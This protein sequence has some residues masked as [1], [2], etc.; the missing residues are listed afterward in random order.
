VARSLASLSA[1]LR[2]QV[3]ILVNRRGNITH[4]VV[5]DH[6]GLFIPD[7]SGYRSATSRLR[8]LRL[9]HTHLN[10]EPITQD[11]LTDLALLHLD[12][13]AAIAVEDQGL[14]G[15]VFLAHLLP[16]NLEHTQWTLLEFPHPAHIPLDFLQLIA[17]LEEEFER[18]QRPGRLQGVQEKAILV[19]VSI[20]AKHEAIDS[21]EE[22][23]DLAHSCNIA[24]A[25]KIIQHRQHIDPRHLLGAGKLRE[26]AIRSLQLGA[27]LLIFDGELTPTQVK[28]I[29]D[30]TEM[31]VIDRT[32][33]ILDIFSQRAHSKEGKIQ[34]ELAQLKYRLPRLVQK[35][36]ALSRLMGGIG[37]RGPGEQKLEIDRRRVRE[38]II[39]LE[40]EIG[41]L[42]HRRGT[43]RKQRTKGDVPIIS[44]VGYTNAGKSTLLNSL[45]HSSVRVEDRLFATL[46]PASRRLRFPRDTEAIITDTVGFIRDLPK[47]LVTAFRATL[48]ELN[49]ADLLVH[50]IDISNPNYE[51]QMEACEKLLTHLELDQ[52]PLIRV[53]NKADRFED[54]AV[55]D[56]LARLH[57]AINISA[58]DPPT[59]IPL[60]ERIEEMLLRLRPP[61]NTSVNKL[62]VPADLF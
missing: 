41:K 21:L 56:N 13:V 16:D 19:S 17:S 40:K 31:K 34:V 51:R 27:T 38:R 60:T 62:R 35:N 43:T 54:K 23:H 25:E 55:L 59:L 11:D 3:G 30:Q 58:L 57:E 1:E 45:T 46:D 8:G 48:E 24:V 12:L 50:V 18:K 44:I 4:V 32:Q 47:D 28:S 39:R 22:L 61:S 9:V 52:I 53:F 36:T 14:P 20:T 26:V 33:L 2:R 7:L 6:Q 42:Q 5:G 49:E 29:T 15:K 10:Q 37:G